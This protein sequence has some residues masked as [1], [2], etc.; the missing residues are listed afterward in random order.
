MTAL[1]T[2]DDEAALV[3]AD[4]GAVG[5]DP[6]PSWCAFAAYPPG[7]LDAA[8]AADLYHDEARE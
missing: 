3:C 4:C 6:C 1:D 2:I 5:S 7:G 8:T